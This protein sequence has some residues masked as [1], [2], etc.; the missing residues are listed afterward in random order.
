MSR[1]QLRKGA[2]ANPLGRTILS[3]PA[4]VADSLSSEILE[5]LR[6]PGE[7]LKEIE[8]AER[9]A[10]SRTAIREAVSILERD[11]LVE[12]IPRIGARVRVISPEDIE[13]LF[14]IRAYLL[15]LA[16]RRIAE[17]APDSF[18]KEVQRRVDKVGD[19][20][21]D[22]STTPAHYAAAVLALHKLI[23]EA[24]GWQQLK[25]MFEGLSNQALW[26][27]SVRGRSA[28]FLTAERRLE[29]SQGWLRLNAALQKRQALKAEDEAKAML[30]ASYDASIAHLQ[31]MGVLQVITPPS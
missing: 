27:V 3:L 22:P 20:G 18:L 29:S 21:K 2:P 1:E 5:G 16:V 10:V 17:K 23:M 8:L 19:L 30:L 13:E 11:G 9:F 31:G 4:Q 6:A 15:G 14:F 28:S 12:R 25:S 24:T 7:R 26:Q